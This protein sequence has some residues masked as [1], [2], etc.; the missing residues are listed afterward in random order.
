MRWWTALLP[1]TSSGSGNTGGRA[2]A[3]VTATAASGRGR[4]GAYD[5][6]GGNGVDE[7]DGEVEGVD[8]IPSEATVESPCR[9]FAGARRRVHGRADTRE[10]R[11]EGRGGDGLGRTVHLAQCPQ[12]LFLFIFCLPI[13]Q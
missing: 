1:D 13:Y 12:T 4:R 5:G 7:D 3:G 11:E 10:E 8:L 2:D 6:E 9:R